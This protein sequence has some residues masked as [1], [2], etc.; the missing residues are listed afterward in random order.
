VEEEEEINNAAVV[1]GMKRQ[2]YYKHVKNLYK[3]SD[4]IYI[5]KNNLRTTGIFPSNVQIYIYIY[6]VSGA[7][8]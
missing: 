5:N 2:D 7:N 6:M 3:P 1:L 8:R 4:I